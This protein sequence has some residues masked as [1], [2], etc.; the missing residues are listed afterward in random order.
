M[1]SNLTRPT[2]SPRE[3]HLTADRSELIGRAQAILRESL[4]PRLAASPLSGMARWVET[5]SPPP[6][7][8]LRAHGLTGPAAVD[9]PEAQALRE[10]RKA[11][12]RVWGFSIPCREAV[13]AL[14][15]LDHPLV[16]IGAG[17][18][19]WTALLRAAGLDIVATDL[20][21]EGEGPY[22][23]GLGRHA[24]LE[25]L[26]GPQAVRAYPSRDVFCSWPSQ[27]ADWCA[28][29]VR[30]IA[31]GRA[32]ALIGDLPGGVTAT[33][34]LHEVLAERF[35]LETV[36]EIPQFPRVDDR[37]TIHRRVR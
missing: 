12:Q 25:A 32:F 16:E 23:S 15:G 35:D 14:R 18:G 22:G 9:G 30:E 13:E 3:A 34:A 11:F 29:A 33:P 37:L 2:N 6:A 20:E 5:G 26:G 31:V 7:A 24:L 36:V 28:E 19:Y 17:S 4:A 27:G 1:S 10:V 21:A 8:E